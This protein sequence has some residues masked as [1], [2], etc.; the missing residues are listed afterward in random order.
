MITKA[1]TNSFA[2]IFIGLH[3]L[4]NGFNNIVIIAWMIY[5]IQL[6]DVQFSFH[7]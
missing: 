3:L 5:I 7:I 4:V 2:G 6:D 1:S